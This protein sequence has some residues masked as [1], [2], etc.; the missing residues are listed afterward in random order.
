MTAKGTLVVTGVV[1]R[2]VLPQKL[3]GFVPVHPRLNSHVAQIS[4]HGKTVSS[5]NETQSIVF[6]IFPRHCRGPQ[7]NL[8]ARTNPPLDACIF[9]CCVWVLASTFWH[10]V[11][12]PRF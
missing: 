4:E 8:L 7:F 9:E 10:P 12:S 5:F 2:S 11:V 1:L 6:V 3:V